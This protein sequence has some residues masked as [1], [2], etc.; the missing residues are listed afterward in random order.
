M[1]TKE[2]EIPND[3]IELLS[4]EYGMAF[5]SNKIKV[6]RFDWD[7]WTD[8]QSASVGIRGDVNSGVGV[9]VN[10][11]DIQFNLVS[12]GIVEAPWVVNDISVLKK[13]PHVLGEFLIK[14][15]KEANMVGDKKKVSSEA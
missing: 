9:K 15:V 11:K 14:A 13:F 7:E 4:T 1:W 5:P 8:I 6:K 3:L 10:T 2:V 12:R